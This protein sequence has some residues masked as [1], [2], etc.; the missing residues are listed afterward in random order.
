MFNHEMECLDTIERNG[1]VYIGM[2][3]VPQN[4]GKFAHHRLDTGT[5]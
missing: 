5:C 2:V 1:C 3:N 4:I